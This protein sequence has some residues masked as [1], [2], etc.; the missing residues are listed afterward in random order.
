VSVDT[1][2]KKRNGAHVRGFVCQLVLVVVALV[3]CFQVPAHAAP[4]GPASSQPVTSERRV[5]EP[6]GTQDVGVFYINNATSRCMDDSLDYGLRTINCNWLNFQRF[7]LIPAGYNT[8]YIKNVQTGRCVDDS[9][10]YGLRA[11]GCNGLTYQRWW[12]SNYSGGLVIQSVETARCIDD[13]FAYGLRTFNC[14]WTA[15]QTWN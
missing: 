7:T 4:S 5:E 2:Q 1:H 12:L 13:S 6:I 9:W 15:F 10:A 8:Y 3:A 14:N 11:F